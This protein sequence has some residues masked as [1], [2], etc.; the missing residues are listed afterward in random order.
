[1]FFANKKAPKKGAAIHDRL[2]K[3]KTLPP[4]CMILTPSTQNAQARSSFQD[5]FI[6]SGAKRAV[7]TY[8]YRTCRELIARNG[9]FAELVA[10]Q[11]LDEKQEQ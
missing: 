8:V 9:F 10:R 2:G 11:R 7:N 1:M 3:A 6:I 4:I 5:A